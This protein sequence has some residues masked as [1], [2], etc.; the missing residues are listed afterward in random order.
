MKSQLLKDESYPEKFNFLA[1]K[2]LCSL[3][4]A[5]D[6]STSYESELHDGKQP[7]KLYW[8]E[9]NFFIFDFW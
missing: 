7:H 3:N 9:A 2:Y 4:F 1:W 5:S 8:P 6:S